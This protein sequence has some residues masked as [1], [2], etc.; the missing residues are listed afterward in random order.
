[1]PQQRW[2]KDEPP[3]TSSVLTPAHFPRPLRLSLFPP[4]LLPSTSPTHCRRR[5]RTTTAAPAV[6]RSPRRAFPLLRRLLHLPRPRPQAGR[7]RSARYLPVFDLRPPRVAAVS[8]VS[9]H[10]ASSPGLPCNGNGGAQE[11]DDTTDDYY[12]L[13]GAYYY[14]ETVDD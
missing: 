3:P 14:V 7:S 8:I 11:P 5:H 12:Y 1:M 2:D 6:P 10:R 9:G 13:E 4:D